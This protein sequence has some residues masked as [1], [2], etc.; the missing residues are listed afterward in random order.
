MY[1][2]MFN[3][4]DMA[5]IFSVGLGVAIQLI[6]VRSLSLVSGFLGIKKV[7]AGRRK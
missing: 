3:W 6:K 1:Y 4:H 2:R 5:K 7:F